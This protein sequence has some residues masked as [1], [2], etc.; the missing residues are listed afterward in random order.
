MSDTIISY[1][2]LS[3]LLTMPVCAGVSQSA[4]DAGWW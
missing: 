1:W 2:L 4:E 3:Y